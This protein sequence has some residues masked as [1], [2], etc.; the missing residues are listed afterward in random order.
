[1]RNSVLQADHV[2]ETGQIDL[3]DPDRYGEG[4]QHPAWS[5]LRA[6]A[7]VW[8][9][10][11]PDGTEFWS[12]TRHADIVAALRDTTTFSSV[13][14][15]MLQVIGGDQ[16][17]GHTIVLTDPPAHTYLKSPITK[18]M[19]R[20]TTP[21][22]LRRITDEVATLLRPL[23]D[24]RQH[25]FAAIVAA[26]PMAVAGPVL[27]IP[28]RHW[29]DVARWTMAGIVP[30]DPA[31]AT[32]TAAQTTLLAHHELFTVFHDLIRRRGDGSADD[33]ATALC[34]LDFGGRPLTEEEVLMNWYTLAMGTNATTPHAA[35]H[36]LLA[37]LEFPSV[38]R[39]L[40]ADP[41]LVP[42]AIEEALR[43]GTPTHHVMRRTTR[44]VRLHGSTIP[45]NAPVCL[46]LASANR[47]EMV[48]DSPFEFDQRRHPN[49]H[50]SFGIGTHYCTGAR[51]ARALLTALLEEMLVRF[52]EFSLAGPPQHLR[53]NFVNGM[54]ALPVVARGGRSRVDTPSGE[55]PAVTP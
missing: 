52:D 1:M 6:E 44:P 13:S 39:A 36:M 30:H 32:G 2:T 41:G 16:A 17:G 24:G 20:H 49:P 25:D 28:E 7:P 31:Y 37:F 45:A 54:S 9:Q 26:L 15:N 18:L 23:L 42:T 4:C 46:W 22:H 53:S 10:R 40:K 33:L 8:R 43:W 19:T 51:A 55:A 35:S 48:F 27:G 11:T 50:V 21:E 14:G 34:D 3:H 29:D 38:W 12:L 47:D 5:L